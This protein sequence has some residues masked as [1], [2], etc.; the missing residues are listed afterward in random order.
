MEHRANRCPS[1]WA[2]LAEGVGARCP[3]C[4][5][6]LL[7]PKEQRALRKGLRTQR[8]AADRPIPVGAPADRPPTAPPN[9]AAPPSHA[10]APMHH[11]APQAPPSSPPPPPVEHAPFPQPPSPPAP[12]YPDSVPSS[13]GDSWPPPVPATERPKRRPAVAVAIGLVVALLVP[14]TGLVAW[15]VTRRTGPEHPSAWDPRVTDLVAFVEKERGLTFVH[16][17]YVDF[18]SDADFRT[19]V[20]ASNTATSADDQKEMEQFAGM[21]RALGLIDGDVNLL[22]VVNKVQG[23]SVLAYYD[24]ATDRVRVRGTELNIKVRGTL[25]HELTHALQD[26]YFDLSRAG[27]FPIDAQNDTYRPVYEGDATHVEHAWVES[28][29]AADKEAY[30]AAAEVEGSSIDLSGVPSAILH[31]FSDAYTYGEPFVDVLIETRGKQAVDDALRDPPR[32]DLDLLDPFRYLAGTSTITVEEPSL[33]PDERKTDSGAFG[34]MALYLVLAQRLPVLQALE[35]T[36]AWGGDAYVNYVRGDRGCVKAVFTGKDSAGT[37]VMADALNAWAG[38]L[39]SGA[40]TI[41][42]KGELIELNACDP[43]AAA[44]KS[45]TG[46]LDLAV[47]VAQFRTGIAYGFVKENSMPPAQARCFAHRYLTAV[48]MAQIQRLIT[49]EL[50]ELPPASQSRAIAAGQTCTATG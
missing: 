1:C 39:P 30:M 4:L 43:S 35:A 9:S 28:L 34:A 14:A 32:A 49:G 7:S 5:G 18:L 20:T 12:Q 42:R 48:P 17:V 41:T 23:E 22:D 45:A 6:S 50:A 11:P 25:A 24:P 36:D 21:L 13:G 16:P 38:R 40:T 26:Q 2:A 29:S 19:D 10:P 31:F 47:N 3:F 44:A 15:K 46:D 33:G 37:T 27:E 8:R